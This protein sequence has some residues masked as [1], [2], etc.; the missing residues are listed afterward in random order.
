LSKKWRNFARK[1]PHT[2]TRTN[3]ATEARNLF[4]FVLNK[5]SSSPLFFASIHG[6]IHSQ[7]V[8]AQMAKKKPQKAHQ[9][10]YFITK[11]SLNKHAHAAAAAAHVVIKSIMLLDFSFFIIIIIYFFLELLPPLA[12]AAVEHCWNLYKSIKV[13]S[14]HTV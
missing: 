2:H 5:I 4:V 14:H 1:K 11:L 8:R 13:C 12:A 7:D 3:W 10:D 6:F 9:M